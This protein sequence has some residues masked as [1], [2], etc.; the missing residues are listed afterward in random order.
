MVR[1][2]PRGDQYILEPTMDGQR[3]II[4]LGGTSIIVAFPIAEISQMWYIWQVKGGY[5]QEAFPRFTP[6]ERE[7]LMTGITE[8][9][10]AKIFA[11]IDEDTE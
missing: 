8:E 11:E 10:W 4:T 3:T 7:F 6:G 5:I 2:N 9:Q 1:F